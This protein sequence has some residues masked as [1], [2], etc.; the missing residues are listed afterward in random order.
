VSALAPFYVGALA[1][2]H[3]FGAALSI[4]SAAFLLAAVTWIWI[5]ETR[6]R[7]LT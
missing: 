6:G 2:T 7:Q 5:P 4:S 3:G 1:Q